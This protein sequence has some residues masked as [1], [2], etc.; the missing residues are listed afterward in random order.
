VGFYRDFS[1]F[2]PFM[3]VERIY[4][5]NSTNFSMLSVTS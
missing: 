4:P 2:L 5:M 3:R 1:P